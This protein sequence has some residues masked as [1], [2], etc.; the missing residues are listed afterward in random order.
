MPG[1]QGADTEQLRRLASEMQTRAGRLAEL[2][3]RLQPLVM[4][5]AAWSGPDAE[6]FRS[7]WSGQVAGKLT[8]TAAKLKADVGDLRRQ[9][10]DQDRT[11]DVGSE[12][13]GGP[14]SGAQG[15]GGSGGKLPSGGDLLKL[16]K[17]SNGLIPKIKKFTD[18]VKM[19]GKDIGLLKKIGDL[20]AAY[21]FAPFFAQPYMD[22]V[23]SAGKEYGSLTSKLVSK[24][25]LPTNIGTKDLFSDILKLDRLASKA[26]FLTSLAPKLGKGLPLLDLG[27]GAWQA[28][29]GFSSG[30]SFK[31]TTGTLQALGGAMMLAGGAASATGFGAVVG[32]PLA[33]IGA[34][35][36]LGAG[37]ADL[38]HDNWPAISKGASAAKEWAG[39]AA[40]AVK[41]A[42]SKA[43][44]GA[45]NFFGGLSHAFG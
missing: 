19:I 1:F 15:G 17:D 30:D 3:A 14:S 29:Q 33:A 27:F 37:A 25:G 22:K 26:P 2:R 9:A 35:L 16:L 20:D 12:S 42:G 10:D 40:S 44:E 13:G 34:G 45:K 5:R 7:E 28:Y 39:S 38:I 6:A 18:L 11:S 21:V 4:D 31:G 32:A 41:D 23:F 24:L 8:S 36:S 43:V